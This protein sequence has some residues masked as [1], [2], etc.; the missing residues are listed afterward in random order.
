MA[1][2]YKV[3]KNLCIHDSVEYNIDDFLPEDLTVDEINVHLPNCE[4]V[5]MADPAAS[6]IVEPPPSADPPEPVEPLPAELPPKPV[7]PLPAELPP[8]ESSGSTG[9]SSIENPPEIV[10][11]DSTFAPF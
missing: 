7:E 3:I 2:A 1:T 4:V 11:T 5:D 9:L 10:V 8:A 6:P